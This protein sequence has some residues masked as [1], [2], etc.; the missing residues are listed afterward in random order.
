MWWSVLHL[1]HPTAHVLV[2]HP[3]SGRLADSEACSE[4]PFVEACWRRGWAS[5]Q[6]FEQEGAFVRE[7][8]SGRASAQGAGS[9]WVSGRGWWRSPSKLMQ[10]QSPPTPELWL[11]TL[12][13]FFAFST[14]DR[15]SPFLGPAVLLCPCQWPLQSLPRVPFPIQLSPQQ[16]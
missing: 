1:F 8:G 13:L 11:P 3:V 9:G 14:I 7:V 12:L 5:D 10:H 4:A 16:L 2:H 15:P 6:G